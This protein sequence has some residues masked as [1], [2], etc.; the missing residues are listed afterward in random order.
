MGAT[1]PQKW[2]LGGVTSGSEGIASGSERI[3][4]GSEG[5]AGGSKRIATGSEGI[6]G[7]SKRI[8]SG[9]EHIATGSEGIVSGSRG[10]ASLMGATVEPLWSYSGATSLPKLG[11]LS[12]RVGSLAVYCEKATGG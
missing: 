9:S 3:A 6:V 5:I 12:M 4:T 7:G 2:F 10:I 11:K 8:V 1:A